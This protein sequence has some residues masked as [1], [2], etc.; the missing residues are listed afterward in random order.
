MAIDRTALCPAWAGLVL[1]VLHTS[2][3]AFAVNQ[4]RLLVDTGRVTIPGAYTRPH[5]PGV[6]L[7]HITV[8][9]P[10]IRWEH[11]LFNSG[12]IHEY[13]EV[14]SRPTDNPVRAIF[15]LEE[16]R[17]NGAVV[18]FGHHWWGN[19]VITTP[20]V[21]TR[22][23][24][25]A[26]IKPRDGT[27]PHP[28]PLVDDPDSLTNPNVDVLR[29]DF[30]IQHYDYNIRPRTI[31]LDSPEFAAPWQIRVMWVAVAEGATFSGWD[32]YINGPRHTSPLDAHRRDAR[33]REALDHALAPRQR[34]PPNRALAR[35]QTLRNRWA[36]TAREGLEQ[37]RVC[38][39][40]PAMPRWRR[41]WKPLFP[42]RPGTY[43]GPKRE[44]QEN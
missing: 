3:A 26:S 5:A 2:L 16:G 43:T 9:L 29:L 12:T 10:D 42:R 17:I 28:H 13:I 44:R 18:P 27:R 6:E 31:R 33:R 25:T 20:G 40:R 41:R 39:R 36:E 1:L 32:N 34:V 11:D 38:L 21:Y 8:D 24:D 15:V 4:E 7:G 19:T 14:I 35:P 22:Q 37:G 30:V 23:Y